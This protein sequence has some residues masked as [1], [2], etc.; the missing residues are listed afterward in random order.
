MKGTRNALLRPR[1]L[2]YVALGFVL[3]CTDEP[4]MPQEIAAPEFTKVT[5]TDP[6]RI[7]TVGVD[8][9]IHLTL[10]GTV[11]GIVVVVDNAIVDLSKATVDCDGQPAGEPKIGVWL[12]DNRTHVHIKG[13]GTGVIKNCGTGVLIGSPFPKNGE[14]GGSANH[15]DGLVTEN[16]DYD[17]GCPIGGPYEPNDVTCP[18]DIALSNSHDN[19][20]DNNR[21][22]PIEWGI[23]ILGADHSAAVSG[24]NKVSNNLV[25]GTVSGPCSAS[26]YVTSDG[27]TISD[28]VTTGSREYCIAG[29]AVEGDHNL[30][31]GNQ[32]SGGFGNIHLAGG[33]DDNIITKNVLI[34][35]SFGAPSNTFRNVFSKNTALSTEGPNAWDASGACVN[36]TWTKNTFTTA[37]PSCILG[38]RVFSGIVRDPTGDAAF[39][40]DAPVPPDLVSAS[41]AIAVGRLNFSVRFAPGAFDPNRT[42]ATLLLD[43]DQNPATGHP[44]S[45]AGGA[46]AGIIG[47]EFIVDLGGAFNAGQARLLKYMGSPN[48]FSLAGSFPVTFGANGMDVAFPLSSIGNDD[49]LVNFKVTSAAQISDVGFTGVLDYMPNVGLPAASTK[50]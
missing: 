18:V 8:A 21:I 15:I 12:K 39:D 3:A 2:L 50:P 33:A 27:N 43:T 28:N 14:P 6:T 25:V 44:G 5:I 19:K 23:A 4:T 49:G 47:S 30:I 46:D 42:N 29:I 38:T 48:L 20:V 16:I 7:L 1:H 13:G 35:G 9:P 32:I 45:D 37:D 31:T 40:P 10:K 22:T 24:G 36:N 34:D 11:A 41:V 17:I 26:I